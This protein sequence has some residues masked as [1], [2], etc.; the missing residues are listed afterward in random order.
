MKFDSRRALGRTLLKM[1]HIGPLL[2]PFPIKSIILKNRYMNNFFRG[3][4]VGHL[5]VGYV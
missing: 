1:F 3:I 5:A 4:D 2:R